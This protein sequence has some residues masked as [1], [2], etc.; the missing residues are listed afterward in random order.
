MIYPMYI[1]FSY[2]VVLE[3]A[4]TVMRFSWWFM[5]VSR[6]IDDE[7]KFSFWCI[8]VYA[9]YVYSHVYLCRSLIKR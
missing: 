5:L 4:L 9:Y 8:E 6:V 1:V 3:T 2:V 7:C